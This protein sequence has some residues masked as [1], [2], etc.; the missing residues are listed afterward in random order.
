MAAA[1]QDA[2]TAIGRMG[3]ELHQRYPSAVPSSF[4][5]GF[6]RPLWDPAVRMLGLKPLRVMVLGPAASG[7]SMQCS[8]L[9][10]R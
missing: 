6:G 9:A 7:K 2:Q 3:L 4:V 8:M 10:V 1:I 5:W